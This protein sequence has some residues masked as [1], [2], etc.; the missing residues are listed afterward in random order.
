MMWE[1]SVNR[2][3]KCFNQ[4][5]KQSEEM[6]DSWPETN[7]KDSVQPWQFFKG[8]TEGSKTLIQPGIILH[9]MQTDWIILQMLSCPSNLPARLLRGLLEVESW[10]FFFFFNCLPLH[11]YSFLSRKRINRLD[12]TWCTVRRA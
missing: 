11:S 10:S 5:S 9:C 7:S 8:K 2:R 4:K 6:V 12:K 3:E 1:E